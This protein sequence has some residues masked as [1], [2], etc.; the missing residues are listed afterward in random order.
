MFEDIRELYERELRSIGS[1]VD[2]FF[3]SLDDFHNHLAG[4]KDTNP[5]V[6]VMTFRCEAPLVEDGESSQSLR[7][8][9]WTPYR[10]EFVHVVRGMVCAVARSFFHLDLEVKV[11]DDNTQ[12]EANLETHDSNGQNET[13]GF[14]LLLTNARLQGG[15]TSNNNFT[16]TGSKLTPPRLSSCPADLRVSVATLCRTF[17]FHVVFDR[18]LIITQL[19]ASLFRMVSPALAGRGR[20]GPHLS[21]YFTVVRPQVS[22]L[23]AA[24]FMASINRQL[25]MRCEIGGK[26]GTDDCSS[27]VS[28]ND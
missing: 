13:N 4:E 2:S 7:L 23:C 8:Q 11:T 22:P 19:G 26:M 18:N 1:H 3:N 21:D 20:P 12:S 14:T 28:Q 15:P 17:P 9:V 16:Q 10:T 27:K 5:E 6:K 24:G 25:E